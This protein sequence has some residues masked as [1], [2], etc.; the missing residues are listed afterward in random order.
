MGDTTA[1]GSALYDLE[2]DPGQERKLDDERIIRRMRNAI[3]Q[4]MD[5]NNAPGEL[6]ERLGL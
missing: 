1:F 6:Y 5:A 2:A 3:R 4:D